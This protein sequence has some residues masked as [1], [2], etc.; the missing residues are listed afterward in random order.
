MPS[1]DE[2]P[3]DPSSLALALLGL[4]HIR[5]ELLVFLFPLEGMSWVVGPVSGFEIIVSGFEII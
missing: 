5:L 3:D 2:C 1:G 4:G